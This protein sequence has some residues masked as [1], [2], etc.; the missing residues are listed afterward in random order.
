MKKPNTVE[1]LLD[2]INSMEHRERFVFRLANGNTEK[3]S[4]EIYVTNLSNKS[5][6]GDQR[7][8]SFQ[9]VDICGKNND[10]PKTSMLYKLLN[11]NANRVDGGL[12]ARA[13]SELK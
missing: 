13:L 3:H 7:N 12:L 6:L 5:M 1:E 9:Y 10:L 11:K 8:V 2:L 4:L